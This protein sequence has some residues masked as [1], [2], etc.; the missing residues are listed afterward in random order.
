MSK[1]DTKTDNCIRKPSGA[2]GG[3]GALKSVGR[4]LMGSG[5]PISGA[6][7]L[8]SLNQ[9]DGFDCP[10]C[11]WGDPEH[12]SSFEF[13]ENGVKAVAWEATR[14]RVT[15]EFF[16][17]HSVTELQGWSDYDL[18]HQ[19]RLTNPVRYNPDTDHYEQVS[20]D[21]AF[22][23]IA[24]ELN[25]LDDPNK[26][27][28]YTS[29]RASNEAA[30]M[31]QLFVRLYGTNNFPDCS[32]MC[33]EASGVALIQSIGIGKGTVHLE[34]FEK[35]DLVYCV[36]QNPGTNHPR[37][38]SSLREVV[39]RGAKVCVFNTLKEK[40][41]TRFADPQE[42]I[43][44]IRG[45]S[46]PT[47]TDYY[48][49][50]LGGDMAVFRGMSKAVLEAEEQAL[51]EGKPSV[52]DHEFLAEHT[53]GFAD[54]AA[55]V[56]ATPWEHIED[57]SGL[58]EADIR[59]AAQMYIEA[60]R[61]ITA[62]AMG[63]TQ[64][65]HSVP[66]IREIASFMFLK[67]NVG[68]EGAGLCPVRG[69]SNVQGDRTVGINEKAPK[70]LIDALEKELGVEMPREP[71]H[72]VT[73][74]IGAMLD[75]SARAFIALGG[76]FARA[77]PDSTLVAEAFRKL[78]LT[79]NIATKLNHGHLMPGKVSYVLPCLGRTEID[80]NSKMQRQMVTV[81]DSMSMVHGS[82]G[83]N[84]PAS[85]ELLSEVRIVAGIA[86]ATVGSAVVNW[87]ELGDDND[88]IRDMIARVLPAYGNFNEDVRK[89]R[90]F[91][92]RN[93]ATCREWNTPT[94]RANFG[95]AD[96]RA[97]TE[98]QEI[99][100]KTDTFVLQT[101]RSHD[102]YNTTIY[103]MDDRYR[104]VY[105]VRNVMFINK[106][107]MDKAGVEAGQLVD[108][109]GTYDDGRLRQCKGFRVVPYDTPEGCIAGYYPEMNELVPHQTYGEQSFTPTSKSVIVQIA[110]HQP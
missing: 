7:T 35:A 1:T 100:G 96:L 77:V 31:Y 8:L 54:W 56:A 92:L 15:P 94:K 34:D 109:T 95:E 23:G 61:V 43:E 80:R 85:K 82:S 69:H 11:A 74:A 62:W 59:A 90:G 40:G 55:M 27:E 46:E 83:I 26:A 37:M 57:Q 30:F 4:Q 67:G 68:R 104:G 42:K 50:R 3:W 12:G 36:G 81:E 65:L 29:G 108:I 52:L 102:Q 17:K 98:W 39:E 103:G 93:P 64:H 110:P 88:K 48:R 86:K 9:A 14:A 2:A 49:P 71:G 51:A 91:W 99:K 63:I 107:D 32:N 75:G 18:E 10:G 60:D 101:F 76:N 45:G 24:A 5:K 106:R 72:N 22:T 28:F 13:C 78:D 16:A 105:G 47:S 79:V 73:H 44:M 84:L 25:K 70:P 19:G 87:D 6:R 21:E 97:A 66:T 38:L 58:S 53:A 41:L 20:W 89:P 33:H